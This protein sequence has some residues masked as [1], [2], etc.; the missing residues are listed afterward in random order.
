MRRTLAI[1]LMLVL[2]LG[3]VHGENG[4]EGKEKHGSE[5]IVLKPGD[6]KWG[7]APPALPTGAQFAVLVRSG[8]EH[9]HDSRPDAD[10]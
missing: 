3:L 4:K 9:V 5:H 10:G 8:C 7:P 1:G 6:L 2:S